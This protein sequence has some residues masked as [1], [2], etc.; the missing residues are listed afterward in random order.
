MNRSDKEKL[1][2]QKSFVIWLTGLS[3]AGKTT[4]AIA[5]EKELFN[6]GMLT[7]ILDGDIVRSGIN[8]NL[9]FSNKDRLENIRRISEVAKLFVDSGIITICSFVSPTAE[10]RTMAKNIIGENDFIE[11][12]VNAPFDVCEKRDVK[13]MYAKA[14]RGEIR[15]FTGIDAPYEAPLHPQI[16]LRTNETDVDECVRKILKRIQL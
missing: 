3:G 1:L 4:I 5:L 11:V 15:D 6:K 8:N 14:R 9:G 10:M 12:F 16:E 2:K 7:Q 13:G